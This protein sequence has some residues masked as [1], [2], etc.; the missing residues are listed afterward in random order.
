MKTILQFCVGLVVVLCVPSLSSCSDDDDSLPYY[1]APKADIE[2]K[3]ASLKTVQA[4]VQGTWWLRIY[5]EREYSKGDLWY[6]TIKG[7]RMITYGGALV[8]YA[9]NPE[10][11]DMSWVEIETEDGG[12]LHGF[13]LSYPDYVKNEGLAAPFVPYRIKD[14]VLVMG[15]SGIEDPKNDK[16]YELLME[17]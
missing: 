14:N 7:N 6:T 5:N 17:E 3:G 10:W 15:H 9:G 12:I 16:Q 8:D 4:A 13:Y 1:V 2:F 11:A